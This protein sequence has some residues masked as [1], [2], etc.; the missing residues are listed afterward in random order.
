MI[1]V[2]SLLVAEIKIVS[3]GILAIGGIVSMA[4]GSLMLFDA[5]EIGLRVSWWA[6]VPMV[7]ATAGLFLFVIAAGVRA[8]AGRQLL[9][10]SG[11][12]GQL[13]TVKERLAPEGQVLV[14]GEIWRAV[15]EGEPVDAG[16]RVRV[17]AVDGLTLRVA[18]A[19]TKG[20]AP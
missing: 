15:A 7:G 8:L 17:V 5:P 13:A 6:I 1:S 12:V 20:G 11:L 14:S 9:G 18:K 19:D 4:L 10:P 3:H 2:D 16:A